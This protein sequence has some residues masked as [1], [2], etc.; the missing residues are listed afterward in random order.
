[1]RNSFLVTATLLAVAAAGTLA[2]Q[3]AKNPLAGQPE[4]IEAGRVRFL[5]ACSAC[6][7][8][9]GGGGA[10]GP[11]L[12]DGLAVRR[13]SDAHLF[14]A[15]RNGVPNTAMPP[16]AFSDEM[17]WQLAAFVRSLSASAIDLRVPGD[18]EAGNALF[19]GKAGCS[20]CHRIRGQGGVL[21]PDLTDIG[22]GRRLDQIREA[23]LDPGNRIADGYT[24]VTLTLEN[25]E[26]LRAVAR[27]FNNYSAQV[28][29]ASGK[30]HLLRRE[31]LKRLKFEEKSW[32]P[33]DYEIGRA[34]V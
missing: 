8:T 11:S 6:H 32:M 18:A 28:F 30:L 3:E 1:M 34:H 17:T 2:A 22:A 25:G 23:L 9:D 27:N 20:N 33:G 16:F 10:Q 12:I 21:G 24:A 5:E 19:F 7:G 4:A 31:D 14:E 29:D 26:K 15:I 13:A